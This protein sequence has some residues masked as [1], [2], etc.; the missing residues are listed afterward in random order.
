MGLPKTS[1][2]LHYQFPERHSWGIS[3][4]FTENPGSW[5]TEEGLVPV[6]QHRLP[7]CSV[8]RVPLLQLKVSSGEN[9][10]KRALP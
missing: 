4:S 2:A 5:G 1:P 6:R 8:V 9:I 3:H 10:P 7:Y